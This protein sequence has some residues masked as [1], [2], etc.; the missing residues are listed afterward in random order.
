MAAFTEEG[1][2]K[3]QWS[4]VSSNKDLAAE[5]RRLRRRKKKKKKKKNNNN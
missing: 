3:L 1:I 2:P 5:E 4:R